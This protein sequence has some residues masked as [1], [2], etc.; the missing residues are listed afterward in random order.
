MWSAPMAHFLPSPDHAF[1]KRNLDD[2]HRS[3]GWRTPILAWAK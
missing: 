3:L 2:L 1:M